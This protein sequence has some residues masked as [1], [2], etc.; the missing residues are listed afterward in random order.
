MS[1]GDLISESFELSDYLSWEVGRWVPFEF[2]A[3]LR[4]CAC[5]VADRFR[6][7]SRSAWRLD[8]YIA[9]TFSQG[10]YLQLDRS[11]QRSR[12]SSDVLLRHD[13]SNL[14]WLDIRFAAWP[15]F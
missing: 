5:R 1:F 9:Q 13:A 15:K 11:G 2:T 7:S 4:P 6:R 14:R 12:V 3:W 10:V 8:G